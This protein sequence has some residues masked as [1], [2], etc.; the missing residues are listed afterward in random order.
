[1]W[2]EPTKSFLAEGTKTQRGTFHAVR[3]DADVLHAGSC[4]SGSSVV[5]S[6]VL[7]ATA[8]LERR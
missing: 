2:T 4:R 5:P 7:D 3:E 8:G 1:M 6:T